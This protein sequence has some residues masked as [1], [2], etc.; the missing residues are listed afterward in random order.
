MQI[1]NTA[2]LRKVISE[3]ID[4]LR[5]GESAPS[6]ANALATLAGVMLRSVKTDIETVRF[7]ASKNPQLNTAFLEAPKKKRIS[8]KKKG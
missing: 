3:E 4:S 2:E 5:K 7:V 8:L 6:R 1:K